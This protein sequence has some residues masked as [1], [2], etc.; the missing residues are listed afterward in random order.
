VTPEGRIKVKIDAL[1]KKYS[2]YV[3]KPVQFGM[4]KRGLDYHCVVRIG[5]TPVAFFIEAK[6][7]GKDLTEIQQNLT[8]ELRR[9]YKANVFKIDGPYG[10]NLL[11]D[12][13]SRICK[14]QANDTAAKQYLHY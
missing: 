4:G 14:A 3:F 6:G 8:D 11:N 1:L 12:W 9:D 13:L 2:V 7:P 5:D 10:L